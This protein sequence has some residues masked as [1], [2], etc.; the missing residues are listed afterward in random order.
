MLQ[1]EARVEQTA[2]QNHVAVALGLGG[3][4]PGPAPC[5]VSS[6]GTVG[7]TGPLRGRSSAGLGAS[8]T[9]TAGEPAGGGGSALA[10]SPRRASLTSERLG[11][12]AGSGQGK[13]ALPAPQPA[14]VHAAVGGARYDVSRVK[15]LQRN[16]R[17]LW[18]G[19]EESGFPRSRPTF[20]GSWRS[21]EEICQTS[22][23]IDR[24]LSNGLLDLEDLEG[25]RGTRGVHDEDR[26][27]LLPT[28]PSR[29][30]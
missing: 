18:R 2:H 10:Q 12:M 30:C 19:L 29:S 11:W 24:T 9:E 3:V 25:L 26:V 7:A 21:H 5:S 17:L 22:T 15:H 14:E 8:G 13:G 16:G 27:V 28:R 1:K 6:G 4:R 23:C 20:M